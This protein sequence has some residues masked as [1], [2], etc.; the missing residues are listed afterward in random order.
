MMA[1]D[2]GDPAARID[3]I[4]E[5]LETIRAEIETCRQAM[6]LSRAGI[7]LGLATLAI[8]FTIAPAYATATVVLGAITAVIGGVVWLGANKSTKDE[9][10]VR[11]AE[12]E[13]KRERLFTLVATRNGWVATEAPT[14]H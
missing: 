11:R 4:E 9:L 7:I 3:A 12:T 5:T 14:Y 1:W 13:A 6:L 10:D 2:E 8:V